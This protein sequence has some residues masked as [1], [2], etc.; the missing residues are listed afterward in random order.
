MTTVELYNLVH[1]IAYTLLA[2]ATIGALQVG[3]MIVIA[4]KV[5][6]HDKNFVDSME[7]VEN[8]LG[9]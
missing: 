9:E 8:R 7:R 4:L 2:I 5:Q 3:V 1:L 6:T